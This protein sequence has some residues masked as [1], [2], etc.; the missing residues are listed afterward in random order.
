MTTPTQSLSVAYRR[1]LSVG[2]TNRTVVETVEFI[3]PSIASIYLCNWPE[4]LTRDLEDVAGQP[5][6][7]FEPTRFLVEP[8]ELSDSTDQSSALVMSALDGMVYE[9]LRNMTPEDREVPITVKLRMYFIE[10][11]GQLI[12]PPPVWTLH[13]VIVT[14]DTARADLRAAPLRI[15]R[16]GR[17][18][19]ALEIPI[20]RL[21]R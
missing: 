2:K 6:V 21:M 14:I 7:T 11:G 15:Q 20:L 3:H 19:T 4:S 10:T 18:Y 16:I 12:N 5:S 13:N 9:F 17:Y 8:A 1:W